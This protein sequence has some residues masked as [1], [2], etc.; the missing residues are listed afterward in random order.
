MLS[1]IHAA[2]IEGK[3][4]DVLKTV[5]ENAGVLAGYAAE[6]VEELVQEACGYSAFGI[7]LWQIWHADQP[8]ALSLILYIP[9]VE[10]KTRSRVDLCR[11][12]T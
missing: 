12:C 11:N 8:V 1:R 7:S 4:A 6:A 10:M 5:A 2:A 3:G 9:S